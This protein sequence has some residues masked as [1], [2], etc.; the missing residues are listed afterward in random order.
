MEVLQA[1]VPFLREKPEVDPAQECLRG[2]EVADHYPSDN[3]CSNEPLPRRGSF[4]RYQ[5]D[6]QDLM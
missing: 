2:A 3:P 5:P 4:G 1:V 6:W